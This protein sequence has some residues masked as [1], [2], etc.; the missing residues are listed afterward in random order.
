V[1]PPA[2]SVLRGSPAV[3]KRPGGRGQLP[4][5]S[6]AH[7]GGIVQRRTPDFSMPF[8][9]RHGTALPRGRSSRRPDSR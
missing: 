1:S 9:R 6:V 3:A 7:S 8:N 4:K 2:R 5:L